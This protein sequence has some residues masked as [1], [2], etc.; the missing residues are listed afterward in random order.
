MINPQNF[1]L[2]LRGIIL[3]LILLMGGE[4]LAQSQQV[5]TLEECQTKARE[6]YPML[7]QRELIGKSTEYTL[8]NASKGFLPQIV[9]NGQAT[10]QSDV[11]AIPISMPGVTPLSKDQ[12]RLYGE[13]SQP[14]TD[15][16]NVSRQKDLIEANSK[17]EEQRLEVELYKIKERVNQLYF[18]ILLIDAQIQQNALVK[19]DILA[20]MRKTSVAI[21]NGVALKS[22]LAQLKAESLKVDQREIEL[23]ATRKGYADMLGLFINQAIDEFT[24]LRRPLPQSVI[25]EIKRPELSLYDFQKRGL[26]IQSSM[27]NTRS[28]PHVNLFFQG[29]YGRPALNMLNNSFKTYY[30]TGVRLNWNLSN[31]YTSGKEKELITLNQT[32]LD[33][34]RETFLFNTNLQLTQQQTEV[35]KYE[36][37]IATDQEIISL[38]ESVR[39]TASDQ[40]EFGTI[41][42]TDYISYVIAE[43]QAR[44]NEL[45]HQIQMLL[46]QQSIQTI[47]GNIQ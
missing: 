20:G 5:L 19:Q 37:L 38:R 1:G 30:I 47:S 27:V 31:F 14:L 32:T 18:G 40:L 45:L 24:I 12:Y 13:I 11:T 8:S 35:V 26:D 7:K 28:I 34:Q 2:S 43:D 16:I 41:T 15:L 29:G 36:E 42:A 4:L 10:Y 25:F 23:K 39:E 6:N 44:Q 17:T 33:V 21:E 3:W 22:S 9:V 46:A